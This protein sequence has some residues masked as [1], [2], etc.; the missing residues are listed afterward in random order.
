MKKEIN[1]IPTD[2]DNHE[3]LNDTDFNPTNGWSDQNPSSVKYLGLIAYLIKAVQ[4]LSS[5]VKT[6]KENKTTVV[7]EQPEIQDADLSLNKLFEK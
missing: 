4:E 3:E 6:L 7:E 1:L 5:E 2:I